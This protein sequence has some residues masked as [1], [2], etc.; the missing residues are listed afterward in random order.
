[1]R[2][3]FERT[4]AVKLLKG[5]LT[6]V[7]KRSLTEELLT[8]QSDDWI[9]LD[10]RPPNEAAV[11]QAVDKRPGGLIRVCLA[12]DRRAHCIKSVLITGDFF[13]FPSRAILDLEAALKFVPCNRDSVQSIIEGF[14]A[15]NDVQMPGIAAK[16]LTN[17]ILEAADKAW[18]ESFGISLAEADHL[19]PITRYSK[20][21]LSEGCDYVLLP[22]CAKP[23]SCEYRKRE[24]C[25]KCAGCSFGEMYGLAEAVG[26]NP[27]TIQN[28]DHLMEILR[29]I[30]KRGAKGYIGCCCSAFYCKHRDELEEAGVPGIIVDIDDQTCYDL[31]KM[32]E[33]YKGDF[34]AQTQLK[35]DILSKLLHRISRKETAHAVVESCLLYTSDA[36]DE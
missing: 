8:F 35:I 15:T 29:N 32:E 20:R 12:L 22:Y 1:M 24:G 5:S 17:L 33:A 7:E 16:D 27:I 2:R 34:E 26:L 31:D 21:V 28:F 19:Y 9:F 3:G 30:K 4:F 14:F 10:R 6:A 23:P 36:A 11:L 13:T 25:T 18:Y